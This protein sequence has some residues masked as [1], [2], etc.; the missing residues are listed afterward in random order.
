MGCVYS[1]FRKIDLQDS[2]ISNG[3]VSHF[4]GPL[5]LR[6]L[7]CNFVG[8]GSGLLIRRQAFEEVSGYE[9]EL[10]AIGLEGAE[11]KLIQILLARRW[12]TGVAPD[13]LIGY[14][15]HQASMSRDSDRLIYSVLAA[16]DIV[17]R[18]HPDTPRV[19]LQGACAV[20]LARLSMM[21]LRTGRLPGAIRAFDEALRFD[22]IIPFDVAFCDLKSRVRRRLR[23]MTGREMIGGPFSSYAPSVGHRSWSE[24]PLQALL[25]RLEP[26]EWALYHGVGKVQRRAVSAE[27]VSS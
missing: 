23:L 2:V 10:R 27:A 18:R 17:A 4:S 25:R 22:P 26:E 1:P 13:Y 16:L 20:A 9:T 3:A 8:N 24:R 15:S 11:D 19:H 21:R 7:Y 12:L 6:S 5:F 14:R